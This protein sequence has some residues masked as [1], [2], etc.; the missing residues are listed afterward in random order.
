[1]LPQHETAELYRLMVVG[2]KECAVFLMDPHG[3][4]TVWN[5][6][7]EE[8]KGYTADEA[9]GQHLSLLY[10]D[11]DRAAG[12]PDHNLRMAAEHG[13]FSE[14]AWHKR[15]DGSLFWAHVAIT[16][17]R[18]DDRQLLGFSTVT[19]DLSRH[20]L[21][22][23]CERE[24]EEIDFILRAAEAGTWK[25][26]IDANEVSISRHLLNMLGYQ[27]D[28]HVLEFDTWLGFV[29][30]DDRACLRERLGAL[31][32]APQAAP[33]EM[34]LR[35]LRRDHDYQWFFMRANWHREPD[36]APLVL[37]GACVGVDNL[38]AVEAERE[39][40]YAELQQQRA[41]FANILD[42]MPSGI[43]LAEAPSGKLLYQ[44]RAAAAL[45]ERGI[46][47]IGS[48]ADYGEYH[49]VD[50]QGARM[51]AED[52]P[53]TRT[54]RYQET[55]RTQELLYQRG[56]GSRLHCAVTTAAVRDNDG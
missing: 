47:E 44:N 33:I 31:R 53:L 39:R 41:R 35:L 21:L 9:I 3:I 27:R 36:G 25:W 38:K 8:M 29:H 1:M 52:L 43:V 55:T 34:Q 45:L 48:Y 49:F 20:K 2:I 14:E 46:D 30:T 11:Q 50:A 26:N 24:K 5:K 32:S 12:H 16:A 10:T 6:A 51:R 40:M 15:K 22:E 13:Y 54:V 42:Q 18:G 17:L 19:L 28:G 7:A 37:M 56:D 4:I 23:Q